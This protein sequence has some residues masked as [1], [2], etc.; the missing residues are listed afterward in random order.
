MLSR[1][2]LLRNLGGI[3]GAS[4][5]GTVPAAASRCDKSEQPFDQQLQ[6]VEEATKRYRDMEKALQDG[7]QI[8]GP[9][10]PAM[11]WHFINPER[12]KRAAKEGP[13]LVQ[14]SALTYNL[15]GELG[16]VEYLVPEDVQP[17][18]FNDEDADRD[19]KVSEADGWHV[20]HEAQHVFSNGNEQY[21]DGEPCRKELLNPANWVEL[22]DHNPQFPPM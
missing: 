5:V 21:D 6:K 17:D 14:P 9:Y 22:S 10:V 7:Y 18:L 11:G 16:S 1:R 19:L 20:H 3:T 2:T 12:A 8:M 15:D 4:L 13:N